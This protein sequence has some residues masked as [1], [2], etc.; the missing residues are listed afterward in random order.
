MSL[1]V[2]NLKAAFAG[3]PRGS[4]FVLVDSPQFSHFSYYDFPNAQAED[5][6]WRA[7]PEQWQ[8]NQRIILDWTLAVLN[9]HLRPGQAKAADELLKRSPEVQVE[10]VADG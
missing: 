5:A 9:A 4:Y 3:A 10:A 8:L 7:T 2:A 1:Y 6:A